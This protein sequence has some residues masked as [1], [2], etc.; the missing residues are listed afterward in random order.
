MESTL[1]YLGGCGYGRASLKLGILCKTSIDFGSVKIDVPRDRDSSF[2]PVAVKK[3]ETVESDLEEKIDYILSNFTYVHDHITHNIRNMFN[4]NCT[5]EK[6]CLYYYDLFS[7][8]DD[9]A[10]S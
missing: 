8:L 9:V 4:K 3:Y 1:I 5:N 2:I 10:I 7:N 6:L